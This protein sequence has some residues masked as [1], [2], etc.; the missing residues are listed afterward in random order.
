MTTCHTCERLAQRDAGQAPLWDNILR[1]P[2]WDVV[3]SF[4]SAL[5]GWLVLVLRRHVEALADLTE[6][7]A[8]AL[9]L[10]IRQVSAALQETTGCIKTYV[11]Q[12]AEAAEHPHVHVHLVPRMADLPADRRGANIFGYL[13]AVEDERVSED[14]MNHLAKQIRS[15]LGGA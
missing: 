14:A 11:M 2:Y 5:P 8:S 3:H 7:E 6:E 10:L 9:G 13:T 4:N 12:F 15:V 1:T